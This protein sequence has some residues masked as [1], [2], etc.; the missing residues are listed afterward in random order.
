MA[1]TKILVWFLP[2]DASAERG[3]EQW[4]SNALRG[5][6][7]TVTLGPH[8]RIHGLKCEGTVGRGPQGRSLRPGG[9]KAGVAPQRNA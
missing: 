9:P 5:P 7:S 4:R 3:Y 2:R 8:G 1:C 6:G